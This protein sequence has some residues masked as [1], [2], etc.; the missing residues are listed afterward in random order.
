VGAYEHRYFVAPDGNIHQLVLINPHV[1]GRVVLVEFNVTQKTSDLSILHKQ[2]RGG[3]EDQFS[4]EL[5]EEMQSLIETVI[6]ACCF[7]C[8]INSL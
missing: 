7:C 5:D 2:P 6:S 4:E 3:G 1:K 8:W